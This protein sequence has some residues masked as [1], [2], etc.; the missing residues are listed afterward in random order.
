MFRCGLAR[1][2]F[3]RRLTRSTMAVPFEGMTRSTLACLPRSLPASTLTVS[4]LRTCAPSLGCSFCRF[5]P[6]YMV[7]SASDHFRCERDDL[8][9]LP[10]AQLAGHRSE[11]ARAHRLVLLVDQYRGVVVEL[12]VRPVAAAILLDCA[13]DDR[14]H[15]RPL[16]HAAVRG[17]FLHRSGD[18]VPQTGVLAGR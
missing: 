1:V 6:V 7:S 2:C 18:H 13:D 11:D 9:E 10:L 4:P 17:G 12:D 16:L 15:H 5:V 14:L 8:H 3:F